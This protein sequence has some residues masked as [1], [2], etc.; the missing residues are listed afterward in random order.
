MKSKST[1]L[2][3]VGVIITSFLIGKF[4]TEMRYLKGSVVSNNIA[5]NIAAPSVAKP[6]GNPTSAPVVAGD[7]KISD[8]D[9]V[10]GDADAKITIVEFA[11]Y[12]CPFCGAFSGENTGMVSRMK[13]SDPTWTPLFPGLKNDY[14]DTGT[15]KFV[16]KDF[17]FLD[18][19]DSGESHLSAMAAHCS[20][21]QGKY[22]EFY[23]K[24]YSSQSGENRGVFSTEKLK[25]M[26]QGLGLNLQDFNKCIDSAKYLKKVNDNTSLGRSLGVNGTPALFINGR[27][28]ANG[29]DSYV[30]IKKLIEEELAK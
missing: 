6:G 4:W 9:P 12:Q 3:I 28:A 21:D 7:L 16:Y 29:A 5:G 10:L 11:D 26:A 25:L 30:N 18:D 13:S 8:D 19:G 1:S 2:L 20:G 17:A 14:I 15:V 27:L 23:N 24:L 22:W